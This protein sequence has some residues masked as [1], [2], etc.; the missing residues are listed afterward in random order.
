ME[1]QRYSVK[2][3][4]LQQQGN[5]KEV[6]GVINQ[7]TLTGMVLYATPVNEYDRRLVILTKERGKI[8]AFAKG[9]RKPHSPY[10]AGSR[11][12]S[13]GE[14]TL[15]AGRN[16]YNV[17]GMKITEY[18]ED[19]SMD[20]DSVYYGFYFMELASYYGMEN[21]EAGEMLAL[22]FITL[23][24]LRKKQISP[25]LIRYIFELKLFAINGEYPNV[26]SCTE[27]GKNSDLVYFSLKKNG[28]LCND[29]KN[30]YEGI[31]LT[32]STLYTMQFIISAEL[33]KLYSFDVTEQ[34]L[35]EL[36][37]VMG[38]WMAKYVDKNFKSL[39]LIN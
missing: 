4:W 38:R 7:I 27:C 28:A 29:C 13:F 14:F 16:A 10:L 8:T 30:K 3:L 36:A 21:V 2:E 23:K 5:I 26:F 35:T 37:M 11:P 12:F 34:V 24:A 39:E 22:L 9:A 6:T 33:T 15:Y 20:I 31:E 19:I 32:T 18:F 1:R 17:T 25:K